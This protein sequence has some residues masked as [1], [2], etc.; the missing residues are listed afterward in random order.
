MTES[1]F[2]L[3]LMFL[4]TIYIVALFIQSIK[5]SIYNRRYTRI[6]LAIIATII[7]I[8]V[9]IAIIYNV[10]IVDAMKTNEARI[11]LSIWIILLTQIGE[12]DF[13]SIKR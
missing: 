5:G 1:G 13:E 3:V 4:P 12:A 11:L 10:V 2:V 6:R 7:I 9:A 8:Y